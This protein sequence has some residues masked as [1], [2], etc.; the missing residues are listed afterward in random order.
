MNAATFGLCILIAMTVVQPCMGEEISAPVQY[1]PELE[2]QSPDS[3]ATQDASPPTMEQTSPINP[4]S[5]AMSPLAVNGE[6]DIGTAPASVPFMVEYP[7]FGP[8]HKVTLQMTGVNK[9]ATPVQVT[10]TSTPLT[11]TIPKTMITPNFGNT[12]SIT[13]TVEV[14]GAPVQTSPALDVRIMLGDMPPPQSSYLTNGKLDIGK[15]PLQV[16][17][18]LSYPSFLAGQKVTLFVDSTPPYK[19]AT[20]TTANTFPLA[21]NIPREVLAKEFGKPLNI[22]Y[23]LEIPGVPTQTS[24]AMS[25]QSEI[26]NFPA[27]EA[28]LVD[29]VDVSRNLND[30]YADVTQECSGSAP[31][32]YC[33]GVMIRGTQ[34][35]NFDPWNPSAAAGNLGG[36]S[37]SYLR[38]DAYV[39]DVYRN[40]GFVLLPQ[41][42]AISKNQA[43]EYLCVYPYDAWTALPDR[44]DAGCGF[45]PMAVNPDLS[46]CSQVNATTEAGWNS[47]T[48]TLGKQQEQCSL[49]TQ[50]PVQFMTSLKVRANRPSNMPDAWNEVLVKTW[51]QNIPERLPMQAF[52]YKNA[53]GLTEAKAYQQKYFTKTGGWLPIVKLDLTRLKDLPFSY[54]PTDQAIQP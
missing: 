37:F 15:A 43:L 50:D 54:A 2:S 23:T 26:G 19:T 48:S 29:G 30:R 47:F 25:I 11:F 39:K 1:T 9:Y 14:P 21:F 7:S 36:V 18:T 4:L 51:D 17:F 32:Y 46:T 33:S 52:F 49:S 53:S 31:A 8:G 22:Y 5:V 41:Q 42:E 12:I 35:G 27:P 40:S 3:Q 10:A 28:P 38:Q 45:Q 16:P 34:N 44:P 24:T 6:L 20:Q 13:Y